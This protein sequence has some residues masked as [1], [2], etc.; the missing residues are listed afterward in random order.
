MISPIKRGNCKVYFTKWF[1]DKS[2]N[3]IR[4]AKDNIWI[5]AVQHHLR[6][7]DLLV[8]IREMAGQTKF[9]GQVVATTLERPSSVSLL[10]LPVFLNRIE[11]I[12]PSLLTTKKRGPPL[13][14]YIADP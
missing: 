14:S 4:Q 3:F 1:V 13:A 12:P 5:E 7:V 11:P 2:C 8:R 9:R 6:R 10:L